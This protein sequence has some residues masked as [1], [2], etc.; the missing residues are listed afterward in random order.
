M[1][2]TKTLKILIVSLLLALPQLTLANGIISSTIKNPDPYSGN[3]SWF[4][5]YESPGNV[6]KDSLI[7]RNLGDQPITI[8]IYATDATANQAGS[9]SLKMDGEEQK[10][11][12][13]WTQISKSE[14][15]LLPNQSEEI[16]FQINIPKELSPGQYFG[17]IVNEEITAGPC[18]PYQQVSGFCQGNI[19]I[20]TRSGNRVYL[21]IPGEV[22]QDIK[23]TNFNWKQAG[24]II[25]FNFTFVNNGNIAFEPKA[26]ISLYNVF[27]QKVDTV[28]KILGKSL[29]GSTISPMVDWDYQNN[30]G[31][32]TAKTQIYYNQDNLGQLDTLHGTVLSDSKD[33]S[34]FIFPWEICLIVIVIIAALLG[35]Y[36]LRKKYYQSILSH[37]IGYQ[38]KVDDNIM[39]IAEKNHVRWQTIARLNHLKAPYILEPGQNIKIPGKK[40]I[41][42]V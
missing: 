23:L 4:R 26:V 12:G 36:F 5:Y 42:H 17:G 29:P 41:K 24:K 28:E 15:T 14:A 6:V 31:P 11:I 38:I 25:H 27:N 16:P 33:L 39:D 32:L 35:I 37:C 1:L 21:T 20:K 30:F 3:Q 40:P 18:G 34:I 9:F 10:G 19:Q 2:K 8:K 7:L 13:A 22:K